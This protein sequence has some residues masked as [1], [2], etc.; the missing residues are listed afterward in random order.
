MLLQR[1]GRAAQ[2]ITRFCRK[3]RR[4]GGPDI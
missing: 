4:I 3:R 2:L 1:F